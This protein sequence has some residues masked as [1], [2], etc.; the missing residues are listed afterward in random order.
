MLAQH[1]GIPAVL[2]DWTTNPLVALYVAS[3][4]VF[5]PD[6]ASSQNGIGHM[7]PG[8]ALPNAPSNRAWNPLEP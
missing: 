8:N 4:P 7:L 6:S 1:Y 5:D 3:Q 2:L